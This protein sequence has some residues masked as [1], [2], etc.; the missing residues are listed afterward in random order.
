[1]SNMG[2]SASVQINNTNITM[3]FKLTYTPLT[4]KCD[5]P[6]NV[7]EISIRDFINYIKIN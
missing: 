3:L 1:M 4:F 6:E 5:F 2:N 7:N